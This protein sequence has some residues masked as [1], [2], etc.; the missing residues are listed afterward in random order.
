MFEG[1]A[2]VV[3]NGRVGQGV[4]KRESESAVGD[5]E[6]LV[7]GVDVENMRS[8]LPQ[9]RQLDRSVVDESTA[10]CRRQNLATD[11]KPV[12]EVDI[13][14]GKEVFELKAGNVEM[15]L[16]HTL[17]LLV[18][19]NRSIGTLAQ[20]QAQGSQHDG[21]AGT[22]LAGDGDKPVLELNVGAVDKRVVFNM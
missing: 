6:G 12:V 17:L 4:E 9:E 21:L 8:Q 22:G 5:G 16:D 18:G 2:V 7:L 19:Q 11:D 1:G 3:D 13:S 10:F 14:L 15:G 20:E